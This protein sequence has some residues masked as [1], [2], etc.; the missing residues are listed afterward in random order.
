MSIHTWYGF[1]DDSF[2]EVNNWIDDSGNH[3]A[4][5]NADSVYFTKRAVHGCRSGGSGQG[6]SNYVDLVVGPEYNH[7]IGRGSDPLTCSADVVQISGGRN[8]YLA[9]GSGV[10]DDITVRTGNVIAIN[11]SNASSTWQILGGSVFTLGNGTKVMGTVLVDG[12]NGTFEGTVTTLILKWGSVKMDKSSVLTT[13]NVDGG[14]LRW[15]GDTLTLLN[16]NGGTV[17]DNSEAP[18]ATHVLNGGLYTFR[19]NNWGTTAIDINV[20][21]VFGGSVDTR[22]GYANVGTNGATVTVH[23][24]AVL[25]GFDAGRT[26]GIT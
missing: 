11:F 12:G 2:S 13:G 3:T 16:Q 4:P 17:F 6:A 9:K 8:I 24:D 7:D 10:F 1:K 25:W 21:D 14:A 19:E 22:T 20:L 18:P 23:N 26:V 5:G 15:H